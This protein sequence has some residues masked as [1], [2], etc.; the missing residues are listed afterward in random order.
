MHSPRVSV[1]RPRDPSVNVRAMTSAV[2]LFGET[3]WSAVSM[4]AVAR[5]SGVSKRSMYL[6]WPNKDA[7]LVEALKE[8][9]SVVSDIDTGSLE[10]DLADLAHQLIDLYAGPTGPA[11]MR[12]VF[13][14]G[15]A[16]AV[17]ILE[18]LRQSQLRA[19]RA[20]VRRAI[21]NGELPPGT[22]ATLLLDTVCGAAL[23]HVITTPISLRSGIRERAARYATDLVDF[24]MRGR[25]GAL[26]RR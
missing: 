19:A 9:L 11:A 17:T 3:G 22:S 10:S 23:N 5:R 18:E 14:P 1:G 12:L 13:E 8:C 21:A 20:L 16:S 15:D 7:L 25:D 2:E 24:V 4:D 26:D 6:R